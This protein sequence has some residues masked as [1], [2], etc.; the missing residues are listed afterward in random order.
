[1]TAPAAP[2]DRPGW[3]DC[4]EIFVRPAPVFARNARAGV[5]RPLLVLTLAGLATYYLTLPVVEPAFVGDALRGGADAMA[6]NPELTPGKLAELTRVNLRFFGLLSLV[7]TPLL[8]FGV[9]LLTWI[10]GALA[11]ARLSYGQANVIAAFASFP[12]LLQGLALGAQAA[13][14][15]E[16]R[17]TS[18]AG[19][20]TGP[21]R[22]L[23]PATTSPVVLALAQR[24]DLFVLW[25]TALVATGLAVVGR[26]PASRAALAAVVVFV[27][28]TLP[29]LALAALRG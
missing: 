13:L 24:A 26:I 4:L 11:G 10:G 27:L 20:A 5:G 7:T 2:A 19:L 29:T 12:R 18:V 21:A 22:F 3:G 25:I 8:V 17:V 14:L 23:D 9:G 1:M 15:P 28:G 6:R 16:E